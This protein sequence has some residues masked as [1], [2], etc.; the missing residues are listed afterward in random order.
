MKKLIIGLG[1]TGQSVLRFYQGL[2]QEACTYDTRTPTPIFWDEVDGLVVSPGV[3]L[4]A[5]VLVEARK[6]HLPIIGDIE[7]F[8]RQA[9]API[10]AITGTNAKSTVTTLVTDM[11]N[12]TGKTALMG[13]NIGVPALDLLKLPTPD[14]YVLELS[15]FQLDLVDTFKAYVGIVLNISPD[16]L[17]RHGSLEA[18]SRAKERVYVGCIHPIQNQGIGELPLPVSELSQGLAGSHNLENARNALAIT[19]PLGLPLAPQLQVLKTFKGLPHRCVLVR[20]YKG[21]SWYNDSK[22]T[23][24]G[25]TLAAIEGIGAKTAGRL[26]LL[27]GGVAKDQD[28]KPLRQAV[29]RYVRQVIVY[30]Q[31][32]Q[33][34]AEDLQGLPCEVLGQNFVEV[35]EHAKA[36]VKSGD[37]VLLSPASASFDM[38]KN[39]EDRGEQFAQKVLAFN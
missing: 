18:Y 10:I 38:F 15:S 32:R 1:E 11:I 31:D 7:L 6:R 22:G 36:D 26:V 3:P 23:N 16:H 37:A 20:E 25:A 9:K 14:Y 30:G 17:D 21:V 24:V 35:L 5:Q 13:G 39:F 29:E 8:Y 28:F 12:A 34:I 27:L 33:K 4:D 2:Q 19:A